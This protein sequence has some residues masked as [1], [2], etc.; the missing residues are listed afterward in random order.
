M[1]N[2]KTLFAALVA[3]LI[4]MIPVSA[5][6]NKVKN[7]GKNEVILIG[8]I[9]VKTDYDMDFLAKTR[10]IAD[11]AKNKPGQY[12]I[13]FAPEDPDDFSD[14]Y[15]DFVEDNPS[16]VFTNGEFFYARY[17]VNKKTRN[18]KFDRAYKY[19]FFESSMSYIWLPFNFNIDVPAGVEAMYVGSF[20]FDTAAPD[21][22]F[23]SIRLEDEYDEA[24]EFLDTVTKKSFNLYR[25]DLKANPDKE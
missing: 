6:D 10:G 16:V 22:V 23:K 8:R 18:L 11:E 24:K 9:T 15:E 25:A 12:V 21:F 19:Y 14:D 13:P 4:C 20:Y 2:K 17:Q 7:P 3:A 1:K 5:K